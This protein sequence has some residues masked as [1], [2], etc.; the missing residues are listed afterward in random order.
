MLSSKTNINVFHSRVQK[1]C[2]N[3]SL[4]QTVYNQHTLVKFNSIFE[5]VSHNL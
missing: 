1:K 3:I 4:I 5:L 2:Q